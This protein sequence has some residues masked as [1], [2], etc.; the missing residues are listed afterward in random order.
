MQFS[1][2]PWTLQVTAWAREQSQL[3]AH[4][5]IGFQYTVVTDV[6][7]FQSCLCTGAFE[8]FLTWG[9]LPTTTTILCSCKHLQNEGKV[10]A[11]P[12]VQVPDP[13]LRY[14]KN[15]VNLLVQL[16]EQSWVLFRAH[17]FWTVLSSFSLY[18]A[19]DLPK[20]RG[21]TRSVKLS[22]A[23]VSTVT[24]KRAALFALQVD[25]FMA[26]DKWVSWEYRGKEYQKVSAQK[27][28]KKSTLAQ[29]I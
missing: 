12:D 18:L 19:K 9:Y 4:M 15:S 24:L 16:V 25:T 14:V 17:S 23:S 27:K 13:A 3:S 26:W 2:M 21:V 22:H 11:E 10:P 8:M 7:I 6:D 20:P 5:L 1:T 28:L 29:C